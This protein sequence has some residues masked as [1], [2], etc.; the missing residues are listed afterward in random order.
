M[1]SR[2]GKTIKWARS[3]LRSSGVSLLMSGMS[4]LPLDFIVFVRLFCPSE[5]IG[6]DEEDDD[7]VVNES[8]L[9]FS[10]GNSVDTSD[11]GKSGT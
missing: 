7:G 10:K 3:R 5:G 2:F 8:E 1:A 11:A 4:L 6:D 9:D